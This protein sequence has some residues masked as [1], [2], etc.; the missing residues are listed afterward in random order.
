MSRS[1]VSRDPRI[2]EEYE[3]FLGFD[4]R[5]LRVDGAGPPL[6]LLH[7]FSGSADT[8]RP[9]LRLL[10]D[11]GRAAVAVD[12][13]SHG[14]TDALRPGEPVI[15]QLERFTREVAKWCGGTR[16]VIVGN[17]LGGLLALLVAE[18]SEGAVAGVVA[19]CP[20]GL[21][22]SPSSL[23]WLR[24]LEGP[25]RWRVF[26]AAFVMAP[27]PLTKWAVRRIADRAFP[28]PP[29]QNTGFS[30]DYAGHIAPRVAR[31][32]LLALSEA[33][34][35]EAVT[36]SP[37]HVERIDCPVLLVSGGHDPIT[38]ASSARTL[39]DALPG[40]RFELLDGVGHMPQ[41]EAPTRLVELLTRFPSTAE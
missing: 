15:P 8:W 2:A 14:R 25:G 12:L 1:S 23:A 38:P 5:V 6:L 10:F 28:E 13:P 26:A 29:G 18:Q 36:S 32:T 22:Y 20:A 33:L 24:R 39:I 19:V 30:V 27:V 35:N 3:R 40:V 4:T 34:R 21:G 9:V 11:Q 17:S 16:T 41:V 7:G 31:R 37:L